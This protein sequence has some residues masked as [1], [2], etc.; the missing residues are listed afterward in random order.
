MGISSLLDP[1][2]SGKFSVLLLTVACCLGFG[3]LG[4]PSSIHKLESVPANTN[5]AFLSSVSDFDQAQ[6]IEKPSGCEDARVLV[7]Q[8]EALRKDW[9]RHS[10]EEAISNYQRAESCWH[11]IQAVADE[12]YALK[13]LGDVY[14]LLSRFQ[15]ATEAYSKS[16]SLIRALP[17]RG[18][19]AEAAADLAVTLGFAGQTKTGLEKAAEALLLSQKAQDHRREAQA[20]YALGIC[21][22]VNGEQELSLTY[23]KRALPLAQATQQK[24]L[25]A[26]ILMGIGYVHH[27]LDDLE[28]ALV[29]YG[30]ALGEWKAVANPWG[31]AKTLSSMGLAYTLLGDRQKALESLRPTLSILRQIGDRQAE[32]ATLNNLAYLYQTFGDLEMALQ[33]Y[34]EAMNVYEKTGLVIGRILAFEYCGDIYAQMGKAEQALKSYEQALILCR[35]LKN[36]LME[37]DA[38]IGIGSL[39]FAQG[40]HER[41]QQ[42]FVR[43]LA[44]YKSE[45]HWRGQATSLNSLGYYFEVS[46]QKLKALNYYTQALSFAESAQDQ[47]GVSA[48]LFNLARIESQLR[49]FDKARSNLE[50]SLAIIEASRAKV[51]SQD[52]KGSYL[53]SVHKHYESYIDLLMQLHQ[54]RPDEGF[55][56]LALKASERARA[57]SFLETLGEAHANLRQGVDASLLDRERLLQRTIN[58]KAQERMQLVSS[59]DSN[60]LDTVTKELNQLTT[61]YHEIVGEIR[62]SSPN[63]AALTLPEPLDL[64]RIQTEVLDNNS[65][66]LEYALGDKSG[67]LWAVTRT[68]IT[69]YQLPGRKVVE[70]SARNLYDLLT[71]TQPGLGESFDDHQT[72]VA[73]AN[74]QLPAQ[75]A[76]L[77]RIILGPVSSK[78]GTKRLL[79]VPDAALQ[80]VPFQILTAPVQTNPA[81]SETSVVTESR[82]LV[83]DHEIVNEPSAS[84]LALLIDNTAGRK[85]AAKT[86]A[87]FA[88]PVFEADDPRINSANRNSSSATSQLQETDS[89]RALRDVGVAQMGGHIPRLQASR[90]EAEAIMSAAPWWSG[91]E[92]TGFEASRATV[93]RPDIGN[94]RILHFATHGLLN[95]EHP[96]L[97]GVVLSLFD[98]KGQQQ[99]GFLRLHDIYNLKLPVDLVVLSACNTGLGKD[100]RGEGLIGLT[101]GFMYAGASSVVASLWKVDDEA[102]A[103]L[104]RYFYRF[105]LKDGLSP[106]A[107]LRKA[108]VTM[109]QQARWHAPYYWSGFIIQ[110]Q[111]IQ[112]ASSKGWRISSLAL[113]AGVSALLIVTAFFVLK[114]RRRLIL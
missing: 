67:Y 69:S 38:L 39:Y 46:D 102:T 37:A 105:M 108:Q 87:V 63:Y 19:E 12:A 96:E 5:A 113:W 25:V 107:A 92:A 66:L 2:N 52:L 112:P 85:Q 33:Y 9:Q 83:M 60:A 58:T 42:I 65:I 3:G 80:Y 6:G 10:L 18:A 8:A 77:S 78:L 79:I 47:E 36:S 56:A 48:T 22:Y 27:D 31:E 51:A 16:L 57:R 14:I 110:G 49:H 44:K 84:T 50:R 26:K 45:K 28:E 1:A 13:G 55:D 54:E 109:S 76:Q 41:A 100:V 17:D 61:E 81:S 73:K 75:I 74:E 43:A 32:A 24:E 93:M 88:D 29:Y 72:R 35:S 98:E 86:I 91:F 30:Q 82:A 20:L 89:Q 103:E 68:E 95:D 97:S 4:T 71:A 111:Y 40:Q 53:A 90:L 15:E 64:K 99:E 23:H 94:Y 21:N 70:A 106:A 114:R 101:R 11:K 104:M 34:Q 59:G 62:A 7:K